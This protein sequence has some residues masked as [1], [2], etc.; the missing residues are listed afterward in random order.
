MVSVAPTICSADAYHKSG[1]PVTTVVL[2]PDDRRTLKRA[3]RKAA[4]R[5]GMTLTEWEAK[6]SLSEDV[7][8]ADVLMA[9]C[10]KM[11]QAP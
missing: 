9:F 6:R 5:N 3:A 4:I 2:S 10:N 11:D 8:T 7:T 1:L